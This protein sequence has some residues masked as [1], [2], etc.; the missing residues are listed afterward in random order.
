MVG[1][2]SPSKHGSSNLP[3]SVAGLR[4]PLPRP[5][6]EAENAPE[7]LIAE[8]WALLQAI[9]EILELPLNLTVSHFIKL[10]FPSRFIY[11]TL[12]SL[13]SPIRSHFDY[14]LVR[15]QNLVCSISDPLSSP[16][17]QLGLGSGHGK[18]RVTCLPWSPAVSVTL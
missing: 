9:R 15:M 11:R 8:D 3:P 5:Q 12:L 13:E 6:V 16:H 4:H 18:R 17:S 7:W 1:G 2:V 10:S 14:S